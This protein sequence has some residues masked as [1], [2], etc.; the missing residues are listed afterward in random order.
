MSESL[1]DEECSIVR[2]EKLRAAAG[3]HANPGPP[4]S[5][6]FPDEG[7]IF[8]RLVPVV[9][10]GFCMIGLQLLYHQ[11]VPLTRVIVLPLLVFVMW[12]KWKREKNF[13]IRAWRRDE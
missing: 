6:K 13:L 12:S 8:D 7:Q 9:M 2:N 3:C 10:I 5:P 4:N 11:L 1:K